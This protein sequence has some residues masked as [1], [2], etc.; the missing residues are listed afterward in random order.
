MVIAALPIRFQMPTSAAKS[1]KGQDFNVRLK[2]VIPVGDNRKSD[3]ASMTQQ[4]ANSTL[5][6]NDFLL[7]CFNDIIHGIGA[8]YDKARINRFRSWRPRRCL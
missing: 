7:C 5:D 8:V 6:L 4:A 2:L 1:R 3:I